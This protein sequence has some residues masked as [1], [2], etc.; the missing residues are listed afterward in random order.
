MGLGPV[1]NPEPLIIHY[2][3]VGHVHSVL[4]PVPRS[5][6]GGEEH[7]RIYADIP[8]VGDCCAA[9][10]ASWLLRELHLGYFELLLEL[11]TRRRWGT[12]DCVAFVDVDDCHAR[13]GCD[14]EGRRLWV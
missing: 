1:T 7:G 6:D 14:Q 4:G 5:Q 13:E 10:Y 2:Q 12:F 3:D 8:F 9:S 11:P